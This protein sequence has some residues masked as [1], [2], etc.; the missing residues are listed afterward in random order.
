M[1]RVLRQFEGW[2]FVRWVLDAALAYG[3][4]QVLRVA[5]AVAAIYIG[6]D[7]KLSHVVL[8]VV[9][10]LGLVSLAA[11]LSRRLP[12][13]AALANRLWTY[14]R[15][16]PLGFVE[17]LVRDIDDGMRAYRALRRARFVPLYSAAGGAAP[18][19]APDLRARIGVQEP[20]AWMRSVS[21]EDR[22]W[23]IASVL[24]DAGIRARVASVDAFPGGRIERR[25][26]DD[27]RT[28]APSAERA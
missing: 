20:E 17:L 11:W 23:R 6:A 28:L 10:S 7:L 27:G 4:I 16:N 18:P 26:T 12:W 9:V 19:D 5:G 13:R 14:E 25:R 1:L 3:G 21:D 24:A 15:P 22:L 8:G 2:R